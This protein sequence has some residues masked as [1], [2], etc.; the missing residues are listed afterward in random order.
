MSS[1]D[2]SPR[3]GL[4]AVFK[5]ADMKSMRYDNITVCVG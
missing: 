2:G 5:K 3:I 4:F 1:P